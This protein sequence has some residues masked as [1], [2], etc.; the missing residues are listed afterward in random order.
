MLP[1]HAEALQIATG[2]PTMPKAIS[3]PYLYGLGM[4]KTQGTV[5]PT[6]KKETSKSTIKIQIP[7]QHDIL[8]ITREGNI[9]FCKKKIDFFFSPYKQEL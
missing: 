7:T 8:L 3:L 5:K 9:R 2:S 1:S 4:F 6:K